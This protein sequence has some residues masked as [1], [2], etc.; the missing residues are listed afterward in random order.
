MIFILSFLFGNYNYHSNNGTPNKIF[1]KLH[2]K[3]YL[4]LIQYEK[5]MVLTNKSRICLVGCVLQQFP[6]KDQII[7]SG[8][9]LIILGINLAELYLPKY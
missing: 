6:A 7:K 9:N 3:N 8:H 5:N 4:Q 1:V 2:T